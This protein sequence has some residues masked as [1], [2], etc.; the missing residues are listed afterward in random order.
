VRTD[1]LRL[2]RLPKSVAAC[3][4]DPMSLKSFFADKSVVIT[5][6]SSGMGW[7]LA[8]LL[9]EYG[10][11][12]A[13][14]ARRLSNLEELKTKC[15]DAGA[16]EVRVFQADVTDRAVMIGMRDALLDTWGFVDIVVANA[17]VGG[18]NPAPKLDLDINERTMAINFFGLANTVGPFIP[19]MVE[20]RRGQ[21][22]CISSLSAFR[23]L[24]NAA[25][26]CA[27]KS[28][29]R[30]FMESLRVDLRPHGVA[31]SCI[32]PGFIV[33]PMTDHDEFKMPFMVPV[34]KS[35]ILIARAIKKGK[36]I[37]LYPWQM[38]LLTL[39]NRLLPVFVYDRLLPA[40]T[41]QKSDLEP[42]LL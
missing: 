40:L 17:G 32:H 24:P 29:Q 36:P 16:K 5:G 25:S 31:A 1:D 18:L 12:L 21:L 38:R 11:R 26:Y 34:R 27:A 13:L 35:S 19:S 6:A 28:A 8:L 23:G 41:G 9:A 10:A 22:V 37:Y 4:F 7:D 14:S 42:R 30:T 39:L 2:T 15:E 3:Y 20:K 33:S